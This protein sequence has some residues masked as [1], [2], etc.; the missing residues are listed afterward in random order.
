MTFNVTSLLGVLHFIKYSPQLGSKRGW[1]M[2]NQCLHYFS[3]LPSI[4]T[5]LIVACI[6]NAD[7]VYLE[8]RLEWSDSWNSAYHVWWI[9][10]NPTL[11]YGYAHF[12]KFIFKYHNR[13]VKMSI[14]KKYRFETTVIPVRMWKTKSIL[15]TQRFGRNQGFPKTP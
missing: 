6:S 9:S 12:F 15:Y 2:D 14:F 1:W 13:K 8:Q 10:S 11:G 5:A 4:S 7:C 3:Q